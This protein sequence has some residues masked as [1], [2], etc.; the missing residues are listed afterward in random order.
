[1]TVTQIISWP[2]S[3]DA[4]LYRDAER[5][6]DFKVEQTAPDTLFVKMNTYDAAIEAREK[7]VGVYKSLYPAN[8]APIYPLSARR[9]EMSLR[10]ASQQR[11][12]RRRSLLLKSALGVAC[13]VA[14]R[15][16]QYGLSTVGGHRTGLS[17]RLEYVAGSHKFAVRFW[18][19]DDNYHRTQARFKQTNGDPTASPLPNKPVHLQRDHSSTFYANVGGA[20]HR[21]QHCRLPAIVCLT[22]HSGCCTQGSPTSHFHGLS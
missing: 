3:L 8:A 6:D 19:E 22:M 1:V 13:L 14:P 12:T 2:R 18:C 16:L 10:R 17:S 5:R 20:V 4:S 15:G 21:S 9:K 7:L 11:E